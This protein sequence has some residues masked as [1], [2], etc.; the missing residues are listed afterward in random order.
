MRICT[1]IGARPQFIKSSVVSKSI[2]SSKILDEIIIHTGQHFDKNMSNI[3]FDEMEMRKPDYNLGI[4]SLSKG[5]MVGRQL[6]ALEILLTKINPDFI[7]VYGDTNSTLSG[8]IAAA[9]LNI[10]IGHVEAG[11][12]SYNREIPE[13]INRILTDHLSEIC[14]VPTKNAYRNL[15]KE[16]IL[17]S[18]IFEVGDVMYDAVLYFSKIAEKKSKII[19]KLNLKSKKYVLATVHRQKSTDD[20]NNLKNIFDALEESSMEVIMP[21]HP[22]TKQYLKL[23]NIF[24][25]SKIQLIDPIGY[26]DMLMLE[27]KASLI[28]TDSGGVQKEAFFH[29]IPSIILRN[30]TEWTELVENNVS[31]LAGLNKQ[32]IIYEIK[33]FRPNNFDFSFYGSGVA[34]ESICKII[35]EY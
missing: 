11:L 5:A 7:L 13:E 22:R 34:G 25:K 17:S 4:N 3:F 35:Q 15:K 9:Q 29:K 26:L 30:E 8:A 16:G 18:N 32:K 24:P 1:I 33:N 23:Y 6:E 14:F 31:T 10:P 21:I 12:R 20:E 2:A 19:Q 28:V 27:K